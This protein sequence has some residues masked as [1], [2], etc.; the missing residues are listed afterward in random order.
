[1][2]KVTSEIH[3]PWEINGNGRKKDKRNLGLRT[4]EYLSKVPLV[5]KN[6]NPSLVTVTHIGKGLSRC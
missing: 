1:M 6:S 2:V 3:N 4:E 5:L